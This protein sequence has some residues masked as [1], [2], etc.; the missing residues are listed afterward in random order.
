MWGLL[1]RWRGVRIQLDAA[2]P[3]LAYFFHC[4]AI[5][6]RQRWCSNSSRFQVLSAVIEI[7]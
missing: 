4:H 6:M 2:L 7:F 3:E 1:R 5:H